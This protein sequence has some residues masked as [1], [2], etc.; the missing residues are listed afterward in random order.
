M[1]W[2]T[3]EV[4]ALAGVDL[5][6]YEGEFIVLLGPSG[7]RQDHLAR[8]IWAGWMCPARANSAIATWI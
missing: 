3:A 1:A 8:T 7:Q 5:D 2:G 4:Q 6:L